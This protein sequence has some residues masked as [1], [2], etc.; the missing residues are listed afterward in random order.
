M[1][2][3][4][5]EKALLVCFLTGILLIFAGRTLW[6]LDPSA[7]LK[8]YLIRRWDWRTGLPHNTVSSVIQSQNGYIWAGTPS[9]L[10][11]F[12]GVQFTLFN[13]SNIPSLQNDRITSL[14]EDMHQILWIGT[15]GGGLRS[16][17][18]GTWKEYTTRDGLSNNHVRAITGDLG[19]ALWVGTDFGL[20][21]LADGK[22]ETFTTDNGLYDNI[23]TA[24]AAD[25]QQRVWIGTLRGGLAV[26]KAGKL[27]PVAGRQGVLQ[28][29]VFSLAVDA[30]GRVWMGTMQGVFVLN[31]DNLE[32][33][34]IPGT[35]Y[36]PIPALLCH[37]QTV[38]WI[39]T[40][41]DGLKRLRQN[42]LASYSSE[43]GFPDDYIHAL[44]ADRSG[45]LWIGT[46]TGGLIQM[47]DRR[48]TV[49]NR[50]SGLPGNAVT[51]V[52]ESWDGSLWIGTRNNGIC[53]FK[54]GKI[55][56][57]LNTGSGLASDRIRVIG[58]D[59]EGAL[60]I[61]TENHGIQKVMR[62][63]IL[64]YDEDHGLSSNRIT[65]FLEDED[66]T[67]YIGTDNGVNILPGGRLSPQHQKIAL[68]GKNI[69][70]LM[71]NREGRLYAATQEGVYQYSGME[72]IPVVF[73][74]KTDVLCLFE[75]EEGILWMGTKGTGLK[76][77]DGALHTFS[78]EQGLPDNTIF[79]ILPDDSGHFWMSSYNGVFMIR[80]DQLIRYTTDP[81]QWL[82]PVVFDE[83]DG[84]P[85]RQCTGECQPAACRTLTG[86]MVFPTSAGIA[87]FN[88]NGLGPLS[89][90]DILIEEM[91]ADDESVP[92][93][94]PVSLSHRCDRIEFRFTAFDFSA[95]EKI[96]FAYRLEGYDS[97]Y[98]LLSPYQKRIARYRNLPPGKYRFTVNAE[99]TLWN[100]NPASFAF[101]I[102]RPFYQNPVLY[103]L[104]AVFA[105][106]SAGVILFI[107]HRHQIQKKLNKYKTSALSA[108]KIEE[109]LPKLKNLM[110]GEKR[111]LVPDLTLRDLSQ[112]LRIHPN[113][114]SRIIN[115]RFGMSYNDYINKYRI[116]EVEKRLLDPKN[117]DRTVLEIMYDT[118]F[119]SKSVFNTAFKKY[120]GM[121][122]SE[123]KKKHGV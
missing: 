116:E 14:Y 90:P 10:V 100:P 46:D 103:I 37:P 78:T 118:G 13:R 120:A 4:H 70:V 107:R 95:P 25:L 64:R 7:D 36:T 112:E 86:A 17:S 76:N 82:L 20:N 88:P 62:D 98:T 109:T 44:I 60:F 23:V 1:M 5:Y 40:M 66:G 91:L 8:G 111:F 53:Q 2:K 69:R 61:G 34:Y 68:P 94:G 63:R 38:S 59:R 101:E 47:L 99:N 48:I 105:L 81:S 54:N 87:L 19:G 49:L 119:F 21:R 3:M 84:M 45:N 33:M 121:T 93:S 102:A 80:R 41:A 11:R 75:D 27:E 26:W 114:L 55:L 16:Y 18:Q 67:L 50:Q 24:L 104:Y 73:G 106:L 65:A 96:R 123:F 115:E 77:W 35:A 57:A 92:L 52:F 12:D 51:A 39:G 74:D 6:A 89:P 42:T 28:H 29:S 30:R 31:P 22:C 15:D 71:K 43:D 9:G 117:R 85:S 113:H 72:W 56:S 79:S 110:E 58:Q 83:T 122:P 108:K 97:S 32:V